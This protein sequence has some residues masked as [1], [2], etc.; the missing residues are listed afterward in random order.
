MM[1]HDP[2]VELHILPTAVATS[3]LRP[4]LTDYRQVPQVRAQDREVCTD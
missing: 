1:A 3:A 4:P 2:F